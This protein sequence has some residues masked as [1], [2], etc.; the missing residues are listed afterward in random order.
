MIFEICFYKH[1]FGFVFVWKRLSYSI[2]WLNLMFRS[3]ALVV[4]SHRV[5]LLFVAWC[6][7]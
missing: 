2:R 6:Q 5:A 3:I 7:N 4:V 1:D